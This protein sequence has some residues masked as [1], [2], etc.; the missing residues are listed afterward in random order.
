MWV[1]IAALLTLQLQGYKSL[2]KKRLRLFEMS[3]SRFDAER[4]MKRVVMLINDTTYAFN[5]RGAVIEK[6][7]EE[8]FEVV[9]VGQLLK[10][11]KELE[12]M[13]TR[14]IGV[15]TRRHG[16]NPFSDLFLLCAY[17]RILKEEKP[18]VVLTYNIKPNVY[19]GMVCQQLKIPYI[20]NVTGLGKPVET[21]GK[22]QKLTIQ[23]YKMGV[24]GG[25]CTF[26]QNKDN[27]T[28]FE[29]HHMLKANAK[30]RILPG[31]GVDLTNHP[32]LPWPED[33]KVHFLFAARVMKE[34]GI[35]LFLAAARK[36]A[37]DTVLFDVCGACDDE[38]Y[39]A[40]LNNEACIIYHGEQKDMTPFYSTCSCFLYPS[41]YPEGMSNVLL[42]AAASGRP[43]I[44]A[45]RAGCRETLEDG[46][47]GF[48]VPVNDE[49]AVI[50]A[51]ERFLKMSDEERRTMGQR[52]SEKIRKEFDRKLVVQ[53]YWEE[54][55]RILGES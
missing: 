28:F 47:T 52:G 44:T 32:V 25:A 33:G 41:Y 45:D 6:L 9:V 21:P 51:T 11:Q 29:Q 42:E 19:G 49:E 53:A 40:V 1:R 50:K 10:H 17:K 20:P 5:L 27:R 43:V 18:D 26:F 14:L 23:L 34:K 15:E 16:T 12:S 35:D 2:K 55:Q 30:T 36:F 13:G 8:G 7:V 22:L 46:V 24:A 54:I 31:S 4:K 38:N 48:L 39:K 3:L 37:S